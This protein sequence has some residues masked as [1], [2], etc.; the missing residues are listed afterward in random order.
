[1]LAV[2]LGFVKHFLNEDRVEESLLEPLILYMRVRMKIFKLYSIRYCAGAGN[3]SHFCWKGLL[4]PDEAYS[5]S[6]WVMFLYVTG[7]IL[8][9][10]KFG[11]GLIHYAVG[12]P[13]MFLIS[14]FCEAAGMVKV[15]KDF[16]SL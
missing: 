16:I 2:M 9:T 5:H 7:P 15:E 12:H 1:M 6:S 10:L 4:T 13:D 8:D 14:Q 3:H 11:I